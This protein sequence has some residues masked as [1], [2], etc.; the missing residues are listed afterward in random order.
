[1]LGETAQESRLRPLLVEFS[2]I[3]ETVFDHSAPLM[4]FPPL[5][6]KKY[7]LKIWKSFENSVTRT[8]NL[9]NAIVDIGLES[10]TTT[11]QM[12]M[13]AEMQALGMSPEI[14]KR[15]FVDLIIAA[16]D[17]VNTF[18]NLLLIIFLLPKHMYIYQIPLSL[19]CRTI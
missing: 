2:K 7:N 12:G 11:S 9:A 15:I 4:T 14:I 19:C 8:L 10:I 5:L 13:I 6:A 16:G 1:M 18:F 3:V 17:T